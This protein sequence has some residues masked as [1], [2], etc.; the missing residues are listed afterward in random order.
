[1][2]RARIPLS[3]LCALLVFATP[4][5]AEKA[6]VPTGAL[7]ASE[8]LQALDVTVDA[9]ARLVRFVS[10]KAH[11]ELAIALDAADVDSAHVEVEPVAV[12]EGKRVL[13][14]RV[15]SK[16]AGVAWEAV[17]AGR[18]DATLWSG[19]TGLASGEEGERAGEAIELPGPGGGFVVVGD[20][21][22]DLRICGQAQTLL[23]PRVLDP[24]SMT[25]R[26]ATMQR[27][28]ADDRDDAEPIVASAR[29]GARDLPLAHLLLATGA[30]TAI[31]APA[32]MTDGDLATAWSEG[33]PGD[34]HGEFVTMRAP[35]DVPIARLAI[36]PAPTTPAAHGAAPRTFYLVT[37]T[38]T[39]AVVLPED[40]WMHPGASYDIPLVEPIRA[41]CLSLVL[42][43]AYV[44]PGEAHPEVT[45]AELTAYSELDHPGATL[46]EVATA[47]GGGGA[48]GEAA[49]G[50]LERAGDDGL[51][52]A[53][54]AY[55]S[56]DPAGRALAVD[57]AIGAG[58]C[59][60]SAPLLIA[61][62]GDRDP[63]VARKG[64]EK[65]ER[66]AKR[67]TRALVS[68]VRGTDMAARATAARLLATVAPSEAIDPLVEVLGQG[69]PGTR[70]AV[71]T[72]LA[73]SAASAS[74][75]RV[76]ALIGDDKRPAD[77][78]VELLR[79]LASRL[80]EAPALAS[81]AI[82]ALLAGA[83]FTRRYLLVEPTA[84]LAAG[85]NAAAEAR[86]A[87]M[88]VEDP[89][90]PVRAH[91]AE[92]AMGSS[93]ES[94]ALEHAVDDSSPRVREAALR[95]FTASK[96]APV[97]V[98]AHR[99]A[100]DEWT[101]VR[102]AAAGALA[103]FAPV[104]KVDD[105]LQKA[106]Q[107]RAPTV[108][109]Q[110]ILALA[111]HGA[112]RAASLIRARLDDPDETLET[113]IAAIRALSTLCDVGSADLLTSIARRGALPLAT[114]DDLLLSLEATNALGA[115]HPHDLAS[116]LAPL[117][118]SGTSAEARAAASRALASPATCR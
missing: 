33:R 99:L 109:A 113:R 67:A 15:P 18:D 8:G 96:S 43:K 9:A 40:A 26:G 117:A 64:R 103:S 16:R 24:K 17:L 107:D 100:S 7:P 78:R 42:D 82:D 118:A 47:L 116:R 108:R 49:K 36:T 110:V 94:A 72:A 10:G 70:A 21:R 62:A 105:A 44:R 90:A 61:A 89:D 106:L 57:A 52:A 73:K 98:I 76:A 63:E 38:R 104:E 84:A 37:D 39:I 50:V 11:G 19:V 14:V 51:V 45:I 92:S 95:A 34:G 111:A 30:S 80:A 29:G 58:T 55:A 69:E 56:L 22:E 2:R 54:A 77:A 35:A 66:C 6:A 85:G 27:L 87:A 102:A 53:S 48:R 60:A 46:R 114:E 81:S 97:E 32:A 74:S 5:F 86:L 68:A 91:A 83:T 28:S 115:V 12:G 1:M 13:H 93:G 71:R 20:V 59:E 88:I 41:S 23:T 25:F 79:A 75:A 112:R 4:A 31:G 3:T 65:L 101:F